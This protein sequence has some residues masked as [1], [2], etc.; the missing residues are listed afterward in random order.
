MSELIRDPRANIAWRLTEQALKSPHSPA[1]TCALKPSRSWQRRYTHLTFQQ[2][3][4]KSAQLALGLSRL[5][6]KVGDRAV[7]MVRPGP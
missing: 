2:L 3:N 1:V 6:L 7:L 4:R 5:G